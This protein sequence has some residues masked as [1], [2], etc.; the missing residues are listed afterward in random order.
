VP[1]L[2]APSLLRRSFPRRRRTRS[3]T[4]RRR[5]KTRHP[6]CTC[7]TRRSRCRCRSSRSRCADGPW[8]TT[9]RAR[10]RTPPPERRSRAPG[11]SC[12]PPLRARPFRRRRVRR[13]RQG[14][15]CH[16]SRSWQNRCFRTRPRRASAPR[17]KTTEASRVASSSAFF[18]TTQQ[19]DRGAA[20]RLGTR[21]RVPAVS[22][23]AA[24][25][26]RRRG[27]IGRERASRRRERTMA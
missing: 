4:G 25:R 18:A 1:S 20:G 14:P 26:Q 21:N 5:R 15:C 19:V 10:R 7:R 13:P 3:C 6:P 23:C 11:T 24:P 12:S 22:A 27:L 16:R 17:G 2:L 8:G 9:P